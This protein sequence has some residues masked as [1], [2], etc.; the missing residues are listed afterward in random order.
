[1]QVFSGMPILSLLLRDFLAIYDQSRRRRTRR[2]YFGF[3]GSQ[4][5]LQKLSVV[6]HCER[7]G[8]PTVGLEKDFKANRM[9]SEGFLEPNESY[10]AEPTP[11]PFFFVP[12]VSR[13]NLFRN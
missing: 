13:R 10:N 9:D 7:A 8:G 3:S 2:R 6:C 11:E 12:I 4:K 1:M 5:A